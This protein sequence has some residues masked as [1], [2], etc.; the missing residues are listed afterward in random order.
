MTKDEARRNDEIRNDEKHRFPHSSFLLRISFVI[1]HSCFVIL[2]VLQK[3][4]HRRW[5]EFLPAVQEFELDQKDR[6][7]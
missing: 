7:D 4:R 3:R 6:L 2:L 5:L 1:C